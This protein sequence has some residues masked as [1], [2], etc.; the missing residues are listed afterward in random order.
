[1][2]IGLSSDSGF[3]SAPKPYHAVVNDKT[4]SIKKI[5][6]WKYVKKKVSNSSKLKGFVSVSWYRCNFCVFMETEEKR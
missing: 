1:M 5:N 6:F 3:K 2:S 4:T